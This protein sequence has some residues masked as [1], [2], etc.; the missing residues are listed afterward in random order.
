M[1]GFGNKNKLADFFPDEQIATLAVLK[2]LPPDHQLQQV[3]TPQQA[4]RMAHVK[5]H[6]VDLA[7]ALEAYFSGRRNPFSDV[8]PTRRKLV[9]SDLKYYLRF[10]D[11]VWFGWTE[12]QAEVKRTMDL[13]DQAVFPDSP[14]E[15][16]RFV[17]TS[18]CNYQ[19]ET[20]LS[21]AKVNIRESRALLGTLPERSEVSGLAGKRLDRTLAYAHEV[22]ERLSTDALMVEFCKVAV[23]KRLRGNSGLAATL[24]DFKTEEKRKIGTIRKLLTGVKG[25]DFLV[26][27]RVKN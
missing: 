24:K 7:A 4:E 9:E 2:D 27:K 8:H 1:A 18:G 14:G 3:M 11:L 16:L 23:K 17:L 12:I 22:R 25:T 19:V 26:Q 10:Y 13:E 6:H 20:I 5:G 21:G 15:L